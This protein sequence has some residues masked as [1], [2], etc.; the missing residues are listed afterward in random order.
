MALRGG[1]HPL[2]VTWKNMKQR[3]ENPRNS[4]FIHYGGRGIRICERWS[5][6]ALF[7]ADVGVRPSSSHSL[8]RIDNDRGYEPGNVRWATSLEQRANQRPRHEYHKL[9]RPLIR[10]LFA[11]GASRPVLTIAFG[12]SRSFVQGACHG[13]A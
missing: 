9:V 12:V 2:Y 1:R 3:C 4:H 10:A 8:D 13:A 6:F 5:D 7:V 11:R